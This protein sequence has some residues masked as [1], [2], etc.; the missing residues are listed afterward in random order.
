MN[1]LMNLVCRTL[2]NIGGCSLGL[3]VLSHAAWATQ[4]PF[5]DNFADR[6]EIS[7]A[8]GSYTGDNIGASRERGEPR[9]SESPAKTSVWVSWV[10][11]QD[12]VLDLRADSDSFLTVLSVY[13]ND[14]WLRADAVVP[15]AASTSFDQLTEL[16]HDVADDGPG[17]D[18]SRVNFPV[19]AGIRY[20]ISVAGVGKTSGSF[21]L[22]W[23]LSSSPRPLPKFFNRDNTGTGS[24]G[25]TVQ[26]AYDV[27]SANSLQYQWLRNGAEIPGANS[28]VFQ[29][30]SLGDD[31]VG[32]Y[33]LRVT[34]PALDANDPA[35]SII[36]QKTEIQAHDGDHWGIR[37]TDTLAE[38]LAQA[39]SL[40][41]SSD[42]SSRRNGD[43][44]SVLP[45]LP[46]M[47]V[48]H[49]Y[50]G[51]QVFSTVAAM[52][53]P[54]EPIHCGIVGGASYWYGYTPVANG[55]M[56]FN[57]VGSSFDTILAV[58]S[59]N[60]A[61]GGYAGLTPI[62][63][64][65]DQWPGNTSSAVSFPVTGGVLYLIVVDGVNGAH[66][67]AKLNYNYIPNAPTILTQPAS[68]T[69]QQGQSTTLSVS[70]AGPL[71]NTYQ[72][73]F[74][75]VPIA[76][77]TGTT[78]SVSGVTSTNSGRYDVVVR[79]SGGSTISAPAT[80]TVIDA[81][82]VTRS[83]VG[84]QVPQ[85]QSFSLSAAASGGGSLQYQWRLNGVALSGATASTLTVSSCQSS[86]AGQYTVVV[87]NSAG[88]VT[89]TAA[90]VTVN[91]AGSPPSINQ[92]PS[93]NLLVAGANFT[94]NTSA[95]GATSYQWYR[96][97]VEVA[98]ATGTSLTLSGVTTS[99]AGD[100][101]VR[102]ANS[103]GQVLSQVATVSVLSCAPKARVAA[104]AD[105]TG[106]SCNTQPGLTYI[107]QWRSSCN[108][109]SWQTSQSCLGTGGTITFADTPDPTKRFFRIVAQQ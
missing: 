48:I 34:N 96:N 50:T 56:T 57:T 93:G 9:R 33:S 40:R 65:N 88:T 14:Q 103:A 62:T 41:D 46:A 38:T 13:A 11:P 89:S 25:D 2:R 22:S 10:A 19:V 8:A 39:D 100:Y 107:L 63:C 67:T 84:L 52:F 101:T 51:S 29:I 16:A 70:A 95:S 68:A 87:S 106:I 6:G 99:Q 24:H 59:Y 91:S 98:G 28:P 82:V 21:Q 45:D 5:A 15:G 73:R 32:T 104:F 42:G 12:G 83:P 31:D 90:T 108:S 53:D 3:V 94:L 76:G 85:G 55:A 80:L 4:L 102:A 43:P 71:A 37:A 60:A 20:E 78:L 86:Q 44:T 58:Y 30:A 64:Q 97:G 26:L 61:V 81:P 23:A 49:S 75:G 18:R 77:A 92:Q 36:T 7:G 35:R 105:G 66:G 17:A 54:N 69:L 109:G 74:G 1:M 47:T 72:W 27:I 79:N